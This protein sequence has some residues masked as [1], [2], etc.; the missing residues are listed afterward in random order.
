MM[1]AISKEIT[2]DEAAEML[3][4]RIKEKDRIENVKHLDFYNDAFDILREEKKG[5][6][7]IGGVGTGKTA[8][9]NSVTQTPMIRC[10]ELAM[11][12]SMNGAEAFKG[13]V[14]SNHYDIGW[15]KPGNKIY[16]DL[17]TEPKEVLYMGNKL[18]LMAY[19]IESRYE[20]FKAHETKTH[21]TTNLDLKTIKERYGERSFSR[22]KEMVT[23]I[24]ING[25]DLRSNEKK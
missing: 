15:I 4:N 16:D 11:K 7:L 5:L 19:V 13:N 1:E 6:L 23:V 9:F 8:F 24:T 22:L 2:N 21:F 20:Y 3:F 14:S 17:G 18:I 25:K 12:Y 10:S